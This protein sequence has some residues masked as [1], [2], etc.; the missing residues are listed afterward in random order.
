ML[1]KPAFLKRPG[2]F[3][4][5]IYVLVYKG[6]GAGLLLLLTAYTT[7]TDIPTNGVAE[8]LAMAARLFPTA[9]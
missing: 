4:I 8:S 2:F 9:P 6:M 1:L 5:D 7:A 3:Q